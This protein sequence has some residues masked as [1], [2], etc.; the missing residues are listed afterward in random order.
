MSGTDPTVLKILNGVQ[1]GV[2]V[3][4]SDGTYL[5]GSGSDADLHLVDVSLLPNHLR[6]RVAGGKVEIAT[7]DGSLRTSAGLSLDPKSEWH[8]LEPLDVVT[9]GTTNFA[10]GP[11]S[12]KWA[13]I[14]DER[15]DASALAARPTG[16]P[17]G[18][19]AGWFARAR[20]LAVPAALLL[21]VAILA[22]WYAFGR[23]ER[24]TSY[25]RAGADLG[26]VRAALDQFPF[27]R[28]IEA[29]QEVDGI[30]YVNG[31]IDTPVE[32]RALAGALDKS[33]VGVRVRLYVLETMRSEIA[34]LIKSQNVDVTFDLGHHGRLALDGLILD[35]GQAE[36]FVA[37]VKDRVLGLAAVD[38]NIRTAETLLT[39]VQKLVATAQLQPWLLLRLDH[40]LIEV[41]GV[42]PADKIDAWVGFL[43]SYATRYAKDIALRSFVQL[44]TKDGK[45]VPVPTGGIL[46]GRGD[47][48][49]G[50][51]KLDIDKLK[52]GAFGLGDVFVGETNSAKAVK[53]D[54]AAADGSSKTQAT[55]PQTIGI[56]PEGP[57]PTAR[58]TA[59]SQ[60]P[61]AAV[62]APGA[63]PPN[64]DRAD[65][66]TAASSGSVEAERAVAGAL[67]ESARSI[68]K[69][70]RDGGLD[71]PA[72][73]KAL[74]LLASE[75]NGVGPGSGIPPWYVPL[76]TGRADADKDHKACWGGTGLDADSLLPALFWL[77]LLS[78][79]E[80]LSIDSLPVAQQLLLLEVA[81]DP[82]GVTECAKRSPQAEAAAAHSLYLR[83]I[84][85][86]PGFIAFI[87]RTLP[88]F[89][90]EVG[91]AS[92]A[93]NR[94]ILTRAGSKMFEG[95]APDRG[96]RLVLVGELGVGVQTRTGL[97]VSIFGPDISWTLTR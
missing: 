25:A 92:L 27:G 30:I 44:Q 19:E 18:A 3:T 9:A 67:E 64:R 57:A 78:A 22:G 26:T 50:D 65:D 13:S 60:T 55:A 96:S 58:S 11:R 89:P 29:H 97:S 28:P 81:L 46:L 39:D 37:L 76:L 63:G 53:S 15:R 40:D 16:A 14:V 54:E 85:R 38:S 73:T 41:N 75:E 62:Q 79:S 52:A 87:T 68:L 17:A 2:E 33:G 34:E 31:Y 42:L 51:V 88:S 47:I 83:E 8:A 20:T 24:S 4:L 77:D 43:Q 10:L 5:V 6:L 49:D 90:I 59:A 7:V 45:L 36:K 84:Q 32:R 1:S 48:A 61:G 12:A 86:N 69:R 80:S 66:G 72:L 35:K 23:N 71:D 70:L 91:G 93:R 74:A 94:F 21:I 82:A 95:A 56:A